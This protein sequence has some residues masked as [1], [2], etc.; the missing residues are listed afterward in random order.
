MKEILSSF[1]GSDSKGCSASFS[2]FLC[3]TKF[4]PVLLVKL[5]LTN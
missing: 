1:I 3:D 2:S 5:P 4:L